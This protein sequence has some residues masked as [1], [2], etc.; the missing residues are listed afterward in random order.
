MKDTPEGIKKYE[1]ILKT[2]CNVDDLRNLRG[3]EW[4][5]CIAVACLMAFMQGV[6]PSSRSLSKYL[7]IP[8]Y[9]NNFT[10][11]YDRLKANGVF[12]KKYNAIEDPYLK[13][14]ATESP[15]PDYISPQHLSEVAWC[16]IA[17]IGGGF[18]GVTNI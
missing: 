6:N 5:G 12:S 17:G 4:E 1:G 11:A 13:G 14:E 15:S 8:L 18:C 9:N 16:H 3:K 10:A 2:I 7:G